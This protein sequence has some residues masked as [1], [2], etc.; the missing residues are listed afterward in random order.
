M[1]I[2]RIA[3]ENAGWGAPRIHGE[4][5]K[6]GFIISERTVARYLRGMGRRGEPA[7]RWLAFLRNHCE[8]IVA[9]DFFAVPTVTFQLLYCL[10]FIEHGRRSIL[11]VNVTRHPNADWVVQQLRETFPAV[12]IDTW[13]SITTQSSVPKLSAS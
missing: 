11:H 5:Q 13:C 1:L 3:T 2:R 12:A 7:K 9:F 4:L 8:V 6:L 10:F